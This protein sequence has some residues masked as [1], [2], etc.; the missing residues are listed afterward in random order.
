VLIVAIAVCAPSAVRADGATATVGGGLDVTRDGAGVAWDA[1]VG[2]GSRDLVG[3]E[4]G[5]VG[6]DHALDGDAVAAALRIA[7]W[8]RRA[9]TPYALLGVGWQ[10]YDTTD[11]MMRAPGDAATWP[12]GGGILVRLGGGVVLDARA[13]YRASSLDS[14]TAGASLGL[15]L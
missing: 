3:L 7:P 15:E 9:W 14:W 8:A 13:T 10:R 4:L 6:T 11:A 2:F 1:R 5:F 12:A